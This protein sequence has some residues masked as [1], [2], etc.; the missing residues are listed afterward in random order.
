MERLLCSVS[1]RLQWTASM[2]SSHHWSLGIIQS[3]N[4]HSCLICWQNSWYNIYLMG[5][6]Q[7]YSLVTPCTSIIINNKPASIHLHYSIYVRVVLQNEPSFFT[8]RSASTVISLLVTWF[9]CILCT[10][11][12]SNCNF[13]TGSN[14]KFQAWKGTGTMKQSAFWKE[15]IRNNSFLPTT[16]MSSENSTLGF[17][18]RGWK[19][20]KSF[21]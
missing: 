6:N 2:L 9:V 3:H 18:H 17:A 15:I 20:L 1:E 19:S 14:T 12:K 11:F 16:S 10:P 13:C 5:I 21:E 4:A 8:V 7:W